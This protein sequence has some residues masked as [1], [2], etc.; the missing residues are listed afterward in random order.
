MTFE[1]KIIATAQRNDK[2]LN[3]SFATEAQRTA[4]RFSSVFSVFS[5]A[6]VFEFV[7]QAE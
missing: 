4:N 3:R 1:I 5:V 6:D 2:N 7:V